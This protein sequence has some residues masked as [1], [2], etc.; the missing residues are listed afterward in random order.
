MVEENRDINQDN[1][2]KW[3]VLGEKNG[4]INLVSKSQVDGL[5]PKGS[6]LTIEKPN[7]SKFILRVD[8]TQQIE[9]FN[10]TPLIVDMGLEG[11]SQ[12]QQCK[13]VV[14]AYRVK[15]DTNR[16]DGLIDFINPQSL[17]RRSNQ[18]EV[19]LAMNANEDGPEV[20]LATVHASEN[21]ILIDEE[22]NYIKVHLPPEMFYHQ[23]L[24]CGRTGKGKTVSTKYLAQYFVE[25][26]HGAVLAINVKEADFLKM[27]IPSNTNHG[28]T[29]KE[30]ADL[31]MGA[32]EISNFMVYYPANADI[33]TSKKIDEEYC[34]KITLSV[35]E[36]DPE[37]LVGLLSGISDVAAQN[38]PNI[39]RFWQQREMPKLKI[40]CFSEFQRY[41][42]RAAENK[43]I[44]ETMNN[45]GD[46]SPLPLHK[47]TFDNI[48]RCLNVAVEFFD[49]KDAICLKEEDILSP[50]K[51]SVIEVADISNG[52]QFGSIL[53]RD[54][55][56][57]IV[58][59]KQNKQYECPVLII[60][61]EV[62]Q[63]YTSADATEALGDLA[64][65]SRTGRSMKIGV[66][67][68][69]QN[70][71][72]MPKGI[73]AVINTKFFF[74]SESSQARQFGMNM[75]IAEV[76]T[77]DNGFCLSTIYSLPQAKIIKFPLAFA[78]VFED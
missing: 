63:F 77:L 21:K 74:N 48:C 4:R 22:S 73:S 51:M 42:I 53:L 12:D 31:K 67:F 47:G 13:N 40:P 1:K 15:D 33:V 3:I 62:H 50:G 7:G 10:P 36:I 20:F 69:S 56:K 43:Y 61:D 17:A 66:I 2:D 14:T 8:D 32:H 11:L 27:Y 64:T 54:L 68:S 26:M 39:F 57:R 72:D 75:D 5:L 37:S 78:G 58:R 46:I 41:F 38:L 28:K 76:E 29:K 45:R 16:N 55:L 59:A 34:K 9:T 60:I 70:P 23:T 65:I 44:F 24:I 6:F 30:W 52:Y 18:K 25:E 35:E 19:N 71:S 49:N